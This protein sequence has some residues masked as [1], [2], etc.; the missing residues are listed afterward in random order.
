MVPLTIDAMNGVIAYTADHGGGSF[1][2]TGDPLTLTHGYAVG[3]APG[4]VIPA[5]ECGPFRLRQVLRSLFH[6]HG[7]G[8]F[9]T[10]V[11][12]ENVYVDAIIVFGPHEFDKAIV[13]AL[14]YGQEAIYNFATGESEE[15][16]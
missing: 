2:A 16:N 10:W 13:T 9:G 14:F 8:R 12:D 5:N 3:M 4:A 11:K 1:T 7:E 6:M 15:V